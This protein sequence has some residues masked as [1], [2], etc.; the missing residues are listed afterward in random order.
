MNVVDLEVDEGVVDVNLPRMPRGNSAAA[1]CKHRG[2]SA[3]E[4]IAPDVF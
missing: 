4:I 1:P 3:V 2:D